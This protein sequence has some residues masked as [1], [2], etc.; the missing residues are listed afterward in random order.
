MGNRKSW[1]EWFAEQA[2]NSTMSVSRIPLAEV[3]GWGMQDEGACFGRPDGKFY[4][5]VG[6]RVSVPKP[7][8]REVT[9]WDQPMIVE[10]GEGVVALAIDGGGRFLISARV[11]PGIEGHIVLGPTLQAS[12]ANLDQAHGGLRPPRAQIIY[13]CEQADARFKADGGKFFH[14]ENE[15]Y[16]VHVHGFGPLLG[17]ERWFT[18]RELNEAAADGL[19]SEH[20]LQALA[21]HLL[22]RA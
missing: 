18:R 22:A 4:A 16:V 17:N 3:N 2:A 7:G 1:R 10:Y 8:Q 6:L 14:K 12:R 19:L 9:T 11:E 15:Y 20:L 5:L 21:L 13:N